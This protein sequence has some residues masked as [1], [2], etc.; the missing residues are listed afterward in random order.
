MQQNATVNRLL[1]S[2]QHKD[3][4][5]IVYKS[6]G[7]DQALKDKKDKRLFFNCNGQYFCCYASLCF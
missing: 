7:L 1:I 2:D 5:I 3:T 4:V 6:A